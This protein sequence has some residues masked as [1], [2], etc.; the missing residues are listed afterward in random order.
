MYIRNEKVKEFRSKL[1][2]KQHD[3]TLTKEQSVTPKIMKSFSNEE[4]LPQ[5]DVSGK[6]LIYILL[7]ID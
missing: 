1:G 7:R 3:I 2:F 5:H 4:I 6:K